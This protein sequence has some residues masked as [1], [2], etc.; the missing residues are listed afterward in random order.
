MIITQLSYWWN[1]LSLKHHKNIEAENFIKSTRVIFHTT[2]SSCSLS[3]CL[4][5]PDVGGFAGK[6]RVTWK[7]SRLR[8]DKHQQKSNRT[9]HLSKQGPRIWRRNQAKGK[10]MASSRS[11][12]PHDL[13]LSWLSGSSNPAGGSEGGPGAGLVSQSD[14]V[15][16]WAVF[17]E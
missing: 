13:D 17:P 2:G 4:W 10:A 1:N 11:A 9:K 5:G 16:K 3:L 15:K 6:V 8:R 14:E 7:T 12:G